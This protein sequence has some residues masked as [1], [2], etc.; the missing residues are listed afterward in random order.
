MSV[1]NELEKTGFACDSQLGDMGFSID[2]VVRDPNNPGHYL[3][4][5]ECDGAMYNSAKSARDRDRLRQEVL[6]RMGWR[7]RRIWSVDWFSNP[8]EVI[9]PIIRELRELISQKSSSTR[10]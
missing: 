6:E 10:E 4:G 5:I 7:I 1:V 9:E 8:D 3:M 2:V